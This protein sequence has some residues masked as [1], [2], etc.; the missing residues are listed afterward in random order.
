[1]ATS[2]TSQKM[3]VPILSQL[4]PSALMGGLGFLSNLAARDSQD[5]ANKANERINERNLQWAKQ[6]YFDSKAWNSA[7]NQ[8]A[9]L[10]A[11]GMNPA[12]M[13]GGASAGNAQVS[14]SPSSIPMQ[15][16]PQLDMN[17]IANVAKGIE[18]NSAERDKTK[19][20]TDFA[21][22]QTKQAEFELFLDNTF[23]FN[24]RNEKLNLTIAE[25]KK[26]YNQALLFEAEGNVAKADEQL[27][28]AQETFYYAAGSLNHYNA[29]IA[30]KDFLNY[31]EFFQMKKNESSARVEFLRKNAS[32]AAAQAYYATQQGKTVE[33]LRPFQKIIQS[34][35]A[36]IAGYDK[37]IKRETFDAEA[38]KIRTEM[39]NSALVSDLLKQQI[40]EAI[41]RN[42]WYTVNE[43][44]HIV[45][46]SL[47]AYGTV[48]GAQT[49]SRA[50]DVQEM[51]AYQDKQYQEFKMNGSDS[52]QSWKI[53]KN[54]NKVYTH[55]TDHRRHR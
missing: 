3:G 42:D 25:C 2:D 8:V 34:H 28:K 22:V 15:P 12:F 47:D 44:L 7:P 49:S 16:L 14:T 54:G 37:Q 30:E 46:T 5:E 18:L 23:K 26:A 11:A 45:D 36:D 17:G 32:N 9:L 43:I 53:D 48:R 40:E 31:S 20:E 41:K 51:K 29:L 4:G 13:F 39:R 24:E 27:K 19:A 52:Y 35:M 38:D 21:K 6:Q 50:V 55:G 33:E 10:R 1:M